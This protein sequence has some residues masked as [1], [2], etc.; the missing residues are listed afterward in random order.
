VTVTQQLRSSGW[1]VIR[2]WE[3]EVRQNADTC[4]L[5]IKRQLVE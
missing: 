1:S 2:I 5:R 4:A 3:H